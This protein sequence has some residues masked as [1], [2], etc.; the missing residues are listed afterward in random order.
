MDCI[1][2]PMFDR[3][4]PTHSKRKFR[5]RSESNDPKGYSLSLR[6]AATTEISAVASTVRRDVFST[7]S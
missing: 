1:H 7:Q 6:L 3:N 2:V 4:A 5:Y